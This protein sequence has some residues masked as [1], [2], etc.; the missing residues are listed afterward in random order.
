M[1]LSIGNEKVTTSLWSLSI[2]A[3]VDSIK[4]IVMSFIVQIYQKLDDERNAV[5]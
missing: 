3:N 4:K 1:Y 2:L 5:H